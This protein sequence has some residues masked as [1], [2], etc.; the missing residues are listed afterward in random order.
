MSDKNKLSIHHKIFSGFPAAA[1]SQQSPF[2]SQPNECFTEVEE[3]NIAGSAKANSFSSISVS[4][5]NTLFETD[6]A[7]E[8][9][10][11]ANSYSHL[12]S[13]SLHKQEWF[14][15][16]VQRHANA[17]YFSSPYQ[18]IFP[19]QQ[20]DEATNLHSS[21][22][23]KNFETRDF[24]VWMKSHPAATSGRTDAFSATDIFLLKMKEENDSLKNS[25]LLLTK[26]N[27]SLKELNRSKNGLF[28][29]ISHDLKN[30]FGALLTMSEFLSTEVDE[31][32]KD[33]VLEF[34][35]T[36]H[37]SA[38][39]LFKFFNDLLEWSKLQNGVVKI[40]PVAI[41]LK[42][43]VDSI[44][45]LLAI[46]AAP[47]EITLLNRVNAELTAAAD[48]NM[49][50]SILN[51]L[52]TNSIKFT[53][54]GDEVI[55]DAEEQNE[56]IKFAVRDNGVGMTKNVLSKIFTL[57]KHITNSGTNNEI[58]SG[59]GLVITKELVLR[60]GGTI[61]AESEV[62]KGTTFYFTLPKASAKS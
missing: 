5:G 16:K 35:Q 50:S 12:H 60:H 8:Q 47:K 43:F 62:G 55:I 56:F 26:E 34:A 41:Q 31:L 22:T 44:F 25:L 21:F 51:N 15:T 40:K 54:G 57:E 9:L 1:V 45:S 13:K 6:F 7:G 53:N 32:E 59:L 28:S 17:N 11:Q 2:V 61:W 42:P 37:V 29:I 20:K 33:E 18:E 49:L 19:I 58:G 48:A 24:D 36:I 38:K 39:V 52:I 14:T 3:M 10:P 30:P 4:E 23:G 46:I 27:D